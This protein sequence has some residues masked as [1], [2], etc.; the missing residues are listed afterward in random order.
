MKIQN[1]DKPTEITKHHLYSKGIYIGQKA[2]GVVSYKH[3]LLSHM[4]EK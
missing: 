2:G 3:S 4:Q 1:L